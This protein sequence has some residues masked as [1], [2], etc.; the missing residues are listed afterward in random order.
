MQNS[1]IKIL[2]SLLNKKDVKKLSKKI[3]KITIFTSI[4]L[5]F[6]FVISYY[7]I[8]PYFYNYNLNKKLIEKEINNDFKVNLNINGEISYS[9]LP[10]P[11][12]KINKI[13]LDFEN[14]NNKVFL[15]ELNILFSPFNNYNLNNLNFK[16]LIISNEEIEI[17]PEDFKNYFMYLTKNKKKEVIIK[18]STLFFLDEQNNKVF[19]RNLNYKEKFNK[20]LHTIDVKTIFSE[21]DFKIKFKNIINGEKN[22]DIKIPKIDSSI[23]IVFDSSSNLN[24]LKGKSKI[25]LSD[26]ILVLNFEGKEKYKIYKSFLRNKFINSKLEGNISLADEPTF[27]LKLDINQINFRKLLLNFFPDE[28]KINFLDSGISK[29]VNGNINMYLKNTNSFIGRI[30]DF[31]MQLIF[32]NGD[33]RIQNG[34]AILPNNS[35]VNFNLFFTDNSNDPYLD[36]NINFYSENTKK[37]LRKFNIYESNEKE[38]LILFQG[39]I[40]LLSNKI[41]FKNIIL[42]KREKLD[43]KDIIT[44]E[45]NFN[46][47]VLDDGIFGITDFFKL[48]KFAYDVLN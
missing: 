8:K 17:Y 43:R 25:K 32:E 2:S 24:N 14:K 41:K 4:F 3:N 26:N 13:S 27:S 22:L 28:K 16:K 21:N 46:Q 33:L 37:F 19:F 34:S 20:N 23:N 18:N 35:K 30:N 9:F 42:N 38:I 6:V 15:E 1:A 48:K 47:I 29:K 39:K 7:L 31:S 11:R 36:F 5:L 40:N 44:L 45:K 12:L 10:S